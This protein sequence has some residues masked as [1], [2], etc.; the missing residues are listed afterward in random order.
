[1]WVVMR[2]QR[3]GPLHIASADGEWLLALDVVKADR[4]T[5]INSAC[6]AELAAIRVKYPDSEVLSWTKQEQEARDW[7]AD[8]SAPTP[9][10]DALAAER[11]MAKAEL[12]SRIIAK[13]DA[14][15]LAV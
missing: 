13:A 10:V 14:Y 15:T 6:E 4:L 2:D 11:G 9:L 3:P 7:Q 8:S 5:T 1:G 12:V